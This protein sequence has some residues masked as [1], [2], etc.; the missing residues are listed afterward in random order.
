MHD[1]DL[2]GV[3][4]ARTLHQPPVIQKSLFQEKEQ[5]VIG[6][7]AIHPHSTSIWL[8]AKNRFKVD[9]GDGT[10]QNYTS[11]AVANHCY[12]FNQLDDSTL[13]K[14]GYKVVT[15]IIT[16]QTRYNLTELNLDPESGD[17]LIQY[18]QTVD[19]LSLD[20]SLPNINALVLSNDKTKNRH[21][22]L[23]HKS[24]A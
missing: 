23:K 7:L 11:G 21:P 16:P 19:W 4:R 1:L 20:A 5:K 3:V 17:E 24:I 12:D 6:K 15:I 10:I 9:W 18:L 2:H 14:E 22:L 8:S 13:T